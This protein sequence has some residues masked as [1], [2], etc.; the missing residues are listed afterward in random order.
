MWIYFYS[1]CLPKWILIV[2]TLRYFVIYFF[3]L[4]LYQLCMK[5]KRWQLK[6]EDIKYIIYN[7]ITLRGILCH[8]YIDLGVIIHPFVRNDIHEIFTVSIIYAYDIHTLKESMKPSFVFYFFSFLHKGHVFW[9]KYFYYYFRKK[10]HNNQRLIMSEYYRIW[11]Y[12][13][14][15]QPINCPHPYKQPFPF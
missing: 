10:F 14:H 9:T 11:Y 3:L 6:W 2:S 7:V 4:N 5:L 8:E 12:N 13:Y 1:E 15:I